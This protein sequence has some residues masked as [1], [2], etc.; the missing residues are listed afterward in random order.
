MPDTSTHQEP[1]VTR[2]DGTAIMEEA[3]VIGNNGTMSSE[4][5]GNNANEEPQPPGN[6]ITPNIMRNLQ[7][8]VQDEDSTSHSGTISNQGAGNNASQGSQAPGDTIT[9]NNINP[10]FPPL[11][12]Q[13]Q[14]RP[15]LG[16]NVAALPCNLNGIAP[17][18]PQDSQQLPPSGSQ[19]HVPPAPSNVAH[20]TSSNHQSQGGEIPEELPDAVPFDEDGFA[21]NAGFSDAD[22]DI[23]LL[24]ENNKRRKD[25]SKEQ[26]IAIVHIIAEIPS[27]DITRAT[28]MI[29]KAVPEGYG[30][31]LSDFEVI[32]HQDRWVTDKDNHPRAE[33]AFKALQHYLNNMQQSQ[34][35]LRN[36]K[37]WLLF[38]PDKEEE[39]DDIG[40]GPR[41]YHIV[42]HRIATKHL[43]V[44]FSSLTTEGSQTNAAEARHHL[45]NLNNQIENHNRKYGHS[46]D[47]GKVDYT[48]FEGLW[49]AIKEQHAMN[50]G[51]QDLDDVMRPLR[52]LCNLFHYPRGWKTA[53]PN[54]DYI[55][56]SDGPYWTTVC[57]ILNENFKTWYEKCLAGASSAEYSQSLSKLGEFNNELA[58][59]NKAHQQAP[60]CHYPPL[61]RIACGIH[62]I[63]T[64]VKS[65]NPEDCQRLWNEL[66]RFVIAE[67]YPI[68]WV[69]ELPDME[70]NW[71]P[72]DP[73]STTIPTSSQIQNQQGDPVPPQPQPQVEALSANGFP[74][75]NAP[76][77]N[78]R[79]RTLAFAPRVS[80]R[81]IK[82]GYTSTGE[83]ILY[84][85]PLGN[86]ANFV[87]ETQDLK[88]R[89]IGSASAGGKPAIE[90][91][92]AA[93][94]Q[95]TVNNPSE[96]Q[97]IR[98]MVQL[99]GQYGLF[100]V[101]AAP[102]DPTSSRLPWFVV[103]FYYN[104]NGTN[105]QVA[106]SRSNL[107]KILS[108]KHADGLIV[109][110]IVGST[111]MSLRE[112]LES[113]VAWVSLENQR[114]FP[115]EA[116]LPRGMETAVPTGVSQQAHS[117]PLI[118]QPGAFPPAAQVPKQRQSL[119]WEVYEPWWFQAPG[120]QQ[121]SQREK[122]KKQRQYTQEQPQRLYHPQ[123][124]SQGHPLIHSQSPYAEQ[125]I[126]YV[127][128]QTA[129]MQQLAPYMQQFAPYMQ[130]QVP[131]MQQQP[132]L[133]QHQPY[134]Q[135]QMA[136]VAA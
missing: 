9:S 89:L 105:L 75:F 106:I 76:Q 51:N 113:Q 33:K 10:L 125:Q 116:M 118:S 132:P 131:Y 117:I 14:E 44:L 41:K 121:Q 99:G 107:G 31:S 27:A 29:H 20:P 48:R 8:S 85:Q 63:A 127:Q 64:C 66:M 93:N 56:E 45:D 84:V 30:L 74:V 96:I 95:Q 49:R 17:T 110:G 35:E 82:P 122:T 54:E 26:E 104:G 55:Y 12:S 101:A 114:S 11:E 21:S 37:E 87:V 22:S 115:Q 98:T 15:S 70:G 72:I 36:H 128:Q 134:F 57:E 3:E 32:V 100:F 68:M 25:L 50:G 38:H 43:Q 78:G 120:P 135:S 28:R 42:A 71:R 136:P 60:E 126:P 80:Q 52:M 69:P 40:H 109:E 62:S 61:E 79:H 7:P 73:I 81:C 86:R 67:G 90:G 59:I 111:D 88:Y 5:S 77:T 1:A 108:P 47:V 130:Q 58:E 102:W 65:R 119:P 13:I 91:A 123:H 112:A 19:A 103:G 2:Q 18:M 129:L 83:K 4:A 39:P 6:T 124:I 24:D 97:T 94:V 92:K 53:P 34:G 133:M 16:P 46:L 23:D